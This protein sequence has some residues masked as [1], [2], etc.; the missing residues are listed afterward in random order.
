VPR[1][2]DVNLSDR[3]LDA[4]YKLV[5]SQGTEAATL[6]AVAK[7]A[8][9]TTPTVYARFKDKDELLLALARRVR[10]T[11]VSGV[12]QQ[13]TLEKACQAYLRVAIENPHDYHLVYEIG[14]PRIFMDEKEQPLLI[15]GRERLAELHG[16]SPKDYAPVLDA[17][18]MEL[19]GAA[20]FLSLS[21]SHEISRRFF[22]QCVHTCN[23]MIEN[24][25][26]FNKK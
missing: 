9:T 24:A 23:V 21:P 18:W 11:I 20:T 14:Y 6:R 13:P 8:K 22:R 5:K 3:I 16:G 15:W 7:L 2:A 12:M 25:I 17:I 4:A 1:V 19:H 10:L 26:L